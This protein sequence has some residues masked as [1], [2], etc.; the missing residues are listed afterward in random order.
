MKMISTSQRQNLKLRKT[1]R[2][3]FIA[4][5]LIYLLLPLIGFDVTKYNFQ[6]I[7]FVILVLY[8]V[9]E[10]IQVRKDDATN[11][12]NNFKSRLYFILAV[13]IF[14]SILTLISFNN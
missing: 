11:K 10:M 13:F 1:L 4:L 6:N 7:F 2:I 8:A 9:Y 12:T 14:W 3:I 5:T